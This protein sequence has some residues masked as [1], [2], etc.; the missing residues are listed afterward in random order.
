[1]RCQTVG[2]T[3]APRTLVQV[4]TQPPALL[5]GSSCPQGNRERCLYLR[6]H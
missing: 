2:P 4:A 3:Q 6:S 5:L 1:M